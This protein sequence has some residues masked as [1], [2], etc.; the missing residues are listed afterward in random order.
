MPYIWRNNNACVA[1]YKVLEGDN[2]LNEF[3]DYQLPFESAG[4]AQLK[5]LRYFVKTTNNAK[6]IKGAAMEIAA[7]F[8]M[9]VQKI[10]TVTLENPVRLFGAHP[11]VLLKLANVFADG[12]KTIADVAEAID[13]ELRFPDEK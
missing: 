13:G 11:N 4:K 12:D 8:L 1:T 7:D 10:Y 6:M 2:F 9:Y 3:E 5:H